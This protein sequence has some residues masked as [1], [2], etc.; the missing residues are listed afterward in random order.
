[1]NGQLMD[2]SLNIYFFKQI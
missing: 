2:Y 1:M